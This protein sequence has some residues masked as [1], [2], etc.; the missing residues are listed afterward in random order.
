MKQVSHNLMKAKQQTMIEDWAKGEIKK[1][2][3]KIL[4]LNEN[5]NTT[6]KNQWDTIEVVIYSRTFDHIVKPKVANWK[7]L[8]LVVVW[9]IPGTYF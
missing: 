5:Q 6:Y 9:L 3:L 8:L 2:N 7:N 1:E 4:E